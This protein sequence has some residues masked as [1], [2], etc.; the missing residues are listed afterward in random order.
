MSDDVVAAV[1]RVAVAAP[2]NGTTEVAGP[3][4]LH[5]DEFV[6][7]GL[8]A[9]KDP[10]EVVT[11]EPVGHFGAHPRGREPLPGPCRARGSTS[12]G[13]ASRTGSPAADSPGCR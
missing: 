3:E 11:A 7:T 12:P 4:E 9:G 2:L 6:R 10:R 8:A 1:A 13:P 5:L